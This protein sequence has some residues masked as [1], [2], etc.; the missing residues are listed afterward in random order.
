MQRLKGLPGTT[1]NSTVGRKAR[2]S[3]D[4]AALSLTEF[5]KW[6]TL[7]VAQR[8]H[9]SPHRGLLGV[10]PASAWSALPHS[11]PPR[12]LPPGPEEALR[13]LVR[14]MPVVS[15][16]IQADGLTL[17][18]LRYWHPIFVAWRISHRN[19]AV[20]YHPED[21]SRIFVSKDGKEYL[22]A[23][24]ADVRQ[25][26]ISLWEQRGALR[27]LRAQDQPDVLERLLF[28]ATEKQRQIAS[29]TRR[30]TQYARG[31]SDSNKRPSKGQQCAP[32]RQ[33]VPSTSE[34]DY[35]RPAEP[36]P[37]EIWESPWHKR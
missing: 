33:P 17:F 29:S 27:I 20:R 15:R 31:Q 32:P 34:V 5:G 11:H 35:S 9:H 21:L 10:T 2:K 24:F 36:F 16:T 30:E 37:V 25:P 18:R 7:E 3:A 13:F 22:E 26:P 28:A 14:F 12:L 23:R 1:G 6:L 4:R 8:Y 19:V